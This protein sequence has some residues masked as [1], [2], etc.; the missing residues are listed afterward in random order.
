MKNEGTVYSRSDSSLTLKNDSAVV[1]FDSVGIKMNYP[2]PTV[3]L[4]GEASSRPKD[5]SRQ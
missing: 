3:I 2:T 4:E 1:S 5:L